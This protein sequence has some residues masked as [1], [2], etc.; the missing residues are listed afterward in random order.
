MFPEERTI[1]SPTDFV[2]D[3]SPVAFWRF[4]DDLT[5]D[6]TDGPYDL[7]LTTGT[8]SYEDSDNGRTAFSFDGATYLSATGYK[9][10]T[11]SDPRA[12]SAWIKTST[13]D[14]EI[15]SW[16]DNVAQKRWVIRTNTTQLRAEN[17]GGNIIGTTNIIDNKWHHVVVALDAGYTNIRDVKLYVDGVREVI[18]SVTANAMDT[19]DTQE[20]IIGAYILAAGSP[21]YFIGLIDEVSIFDGLTQSQIEDIYN[22]G[23]SAHYSGMTWK[24]STDEW[25]SADMSRGGSRY[26]P[27]LVTVSDQ[28]KIYFG[29]L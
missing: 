21:R 9:G 2:T 23:T 11:G 12:I 4:E 29:A 13:P 22:S 24:E 6:A 10:I 28:G 3:A 25:V 18:S 7:A 16:G 19:A 1:L 5:D 17:Q 26:K 14:V 15:I 27:Q 8:E 20:V